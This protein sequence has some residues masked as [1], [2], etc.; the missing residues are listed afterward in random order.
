MPYIRISKLS[1]F[2]CNNL[3]IS[4]FEKAP[5]LSARTSPWK[6]KSLKSHDITIII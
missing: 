4:M 3:K 6:R 5:Q 1:V 2:V